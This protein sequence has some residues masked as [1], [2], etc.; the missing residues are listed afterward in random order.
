MP[1][2]RSVAAQLPPFEA[3][4]VV[5]R[6]TSGSVQVHSGI[7]SAVIVSQFWRSDTFDGRGQD[8]TSEAMSE[9]SAAET[10]VS[11]LV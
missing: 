5:A 3:L 2:E 1:N 9:A 11:G 10:E 8:F 4:L 6:R 7:S